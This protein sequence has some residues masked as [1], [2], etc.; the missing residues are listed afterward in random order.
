MTAGMMVPR[1]LDK[2]GCARGELGRIIT[3]LVK[4]GRRM[5]CVWLFCA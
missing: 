1:M 2:I 3:V 5:E 4:R